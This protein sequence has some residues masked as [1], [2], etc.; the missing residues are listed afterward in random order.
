MKL[1]AV[2]IYDT[3]RAVLLIS[4]SL[5][6]FGKI[7]VMLKDVISSHS[8]SQKL[9]IAFAIYEIDFIL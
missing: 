5:V 6:Y 7:C 1:L 9:Y 3:E 2:A 4:S 8:E